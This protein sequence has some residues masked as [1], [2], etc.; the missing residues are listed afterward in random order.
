VDTTIDS[1][2]LDWLALCALVSQQSDVEGFQRWAFA[3]GTDGAPRE[4]LVR[5]R[6]AWATWRGVWGKKEQTEA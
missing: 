6:I 2:Y 5:G 1:V 3:V 4:R